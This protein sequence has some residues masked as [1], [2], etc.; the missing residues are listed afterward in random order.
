MVGYSLGSV[1]CLICGSKLTVEKVNDSTSPPKFN[2][3]CPKDGIMNC[4]V[5]NDPF[6][7][8]VNLGAPSV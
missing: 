8:I 2:L 7:Y 1:F 6:L 4:Y 5:D 3:K